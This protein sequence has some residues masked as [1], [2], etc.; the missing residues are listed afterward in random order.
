[1]GEQTGDKTEEPTPHRL[2]EA[3]DK[4][5]VAKSKEV[6]T[7]FL[8]ISSYLVL[9]YIGEFVWL[10]LSEMMKAIFEQIPNAYEFNMGFAGHVL[11]IGLRG[12]AFAVAPIFGVTFVVAVLAESLQ[13]GFVAAVD[14]LT[15]KLERINPLEGFKRMFSLQGF[16]ELIKSI[17]K[18]MIVF[19]IAWSAA[20]DE[21]PHVISLMDANP[22]E[23]VKVGGSIAYNIAIRVGI[24]YLFVAILD[25]LY[26]RWE[27]MR[28]LKM[29]KQEIKEEYKRLEGDP[30]IKQRM[31]DLQR[32]AAQQ[33][34]MASVPGADVVVTNPTHLAVALSYDATQM[35][36]PKLLAKGQNLIAQDIKKIAEEH[37]IPIIENETLA[38]AI[39][40][41]TKV[42]TEIASELYQAVAEVLAFV[43]KIKKDRNAKKKQMLGPLNGIRQQQIK[44]K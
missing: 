42:G 9:R 41:T 44:V 17:L 37:F 24:F 34:M 4:G 33:R 8:L 28:N 30:L 38:R 22:W 12:L 31:R 11:L 18:I 39:F 3:R 26:K 27:Y 15:P 19:W 2:K 29:T 10:Q 13:T 43:Y 16:V 1:M 14:P 21:L 23:A 40:R 20:K 7:A 25:Y 5:Q 36:S 35:K 6:T 32:A